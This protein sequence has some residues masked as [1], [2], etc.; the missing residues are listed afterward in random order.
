MKPED[1]ILFARIVVATYHSK[2]TYYY[3][4]YHHQSI[5]H[6][7]LGILAGIIAFPLIV[8]LMLISLVVPQKQWE[9]FWD[10]YLKG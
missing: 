4:Y 2:T 8:L 5:R 6:K 3:Y 1:K 7:L 9:K 10:A